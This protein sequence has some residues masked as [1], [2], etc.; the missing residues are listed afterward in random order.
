MRHLTIRQNEQPEM[1]TIKIASIL[2]VHNRRE[3]TL[4]CLRHLF[5][6]VEA[7]NQSSY[8]RG[9]V[10][11][12]VYLTDDGCTDGTADAIR[13]TFSD[14]DIHIIQGDGNL[15][16]AGGMCKAWQAA[17]DSDTRW[18][19]YLLLNDDTNVYANVFDELFSSEQY[20]EKQYGRE[21][22]VSGFTCEPGNKEKATYCGLNFVSWT[23]GRQVRL[24]PTGQPQH[25]DLTNANILLVPTAVV[26][27][28]GT[29][30]KGYQH[31]CADNDY[32]MEAH[33]H[34]I[35]VFSTA[36]I[37]G[38][39]QHDHH[40]QEEEIK[41][42]ST[43]SKAEREEY[44]RSAI[45]SDR[46]YLLFVRRNMPLRYPFAVIVRGIRVCF[47]PL[48]HFVTNMRGVYKNK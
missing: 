2:T 27:K 30:Y 44:V 21:G 15:F 25:I 31:G 22:L 39:C 16:W 47:P 40:T 28:I 13:E 38:E 14:K 17:I 45:H 24:K 29:F 6:A 37:C 1:N 26:E 3:K 32:S 11:T 18:D 7:Y 12:T 36:H 20:E 9:D 35:P 4:L 34:N 42:L 10:G 48:Y 41:M 8:R 19:Y 5:E 43:L 46:D 33:R 23:R